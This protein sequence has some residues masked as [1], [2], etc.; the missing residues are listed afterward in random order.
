MPTTATATED[1]EEGQGGCKFCQFSCRPAETAGVSQAA[2]PARFQ[3]GGLPHHAP[4]LR[5][6]SL[7]MRSTF[8]KTSRAKQN[9]AS[10]QYHTRKGS[11]I[12]TLLCLVCQPMLTPHLTKPLLRRAALAVGLLLPKVG[13][14]ITCRLQAYPKPSTDTTRVGNQL[15][16]KPA[17]H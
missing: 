3:A 9:N 12:H 2:E 10:H 16:T 4:I 7:R 14:S 1:S 15:L 11:A 17:A 8:A 6:R 13:A 5:M